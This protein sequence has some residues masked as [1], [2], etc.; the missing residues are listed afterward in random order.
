M[1][2]FFFPILSSLLYQF[3]R[4][5]LQVPLLGGA[6]PRA[7]WVFLVLQSGSGGLGAG[8]GGSIVEGEQRQA[9]VG[10]VGAEELVPTYKI[11]LWDP[12]LIYSTCKLVLTPIYKDTW[13]T[14]NKIR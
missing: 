7:Q 4:S 12:G 2:G 3:D 14:Y 10:V 11:S 9:G 6:Q 8:E 13:T 5:L 1:G